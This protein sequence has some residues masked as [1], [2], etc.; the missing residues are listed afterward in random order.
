MFAMLNMDSSGIS[1][2]KERF[3]GVLKR[4][5]T[6]LLLTAGVMA[7]IS[8]AQAQMC[9]PAPSGI[10]GWW[11]CDGDATDIFA[12][13]NGALHTGVTTTAAGVGGGVGGD[14]KV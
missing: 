13:D 2:D 3:G 14:G 5:S 11:P 9:T 4:W 6:R 12:G 8:G 1:N 7:V 10:I